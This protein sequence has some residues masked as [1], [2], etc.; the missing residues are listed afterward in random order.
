MLKG[1]RNSRVFITI[2]KQISYSFVCLFVFVFF[3]PFENFHS[4]GEVTIT[5]EGLQIM[6]NARLSWPLSSE[7]S[8]ACHTYSDTGHPFIMVIH[9]H[10]LQSVWQYSCDYLFLRLRSVAAGIPSPNLP[11]AERTL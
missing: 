5:C 9:S 2:G 10:L 1:N 4:Y 3:V 8:L 6:T 7:D 11:L